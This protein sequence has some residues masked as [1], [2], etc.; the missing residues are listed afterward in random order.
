MAAC[1]VCKK[2][3]NCDHKEMHSVYKCRKEHVFYCCKV[4]CTRAF[5]KRCEKAI[6]QCEKMKKEL[7]TDGHTHG[8]GSALRRLPP[9]EREKFKQIAEAESQSLPICPE[10]AKCKD[11]SV[12]YCC[13]VMLKIGGF[14]NLEKVEETPPALPKLSTGSSRKS[15]AEMELVSDDMLQ[16]IER[17]KDDEDLIVNQK[18]P[19]SA[20]GKKGKLKHKLFLG[21]QPST[22]SFAEDD[23]DSLDAPNSTT[24]TTTASSSEATIFV[25]NR[26]QL[27][28]PAR[29]KGLT[30][31]ERSGK[32]QRFQD[33]F[34][35]CSELRA[36]QILEDNGWDLQKAADNASQAGASSKSK[37][38][39]Q[40]KEQH[41]PRQGPEQVQ[42]QRQTPSRAWREE[43]HAAPPEEVQDSSSSRPPPPAI[44]PDGW[45]AVWDEDHQSYYFWE[46]STNHTQWELPSLQ[47]EAE[48]KISP[49]EELK[50]S[51]DADAKSFKITQMC[52]IIGIDTS[53]AREVLEEHG[54]DLEQSVRTY[55]EKQKR[56]EAARRK[57][58]L[59]PLDKRK[60]EESARPAAQGARQQ[61]AA[62]AEAT[63]TVEA[64]HVDQ[65]SI[66]KQFVCT[67]HWTPRAE[68]AGCLQIFQGERVEVTYSEGAQGWACVRFLEEPSKQ[69]CVPQA[70]LQEA[71]QPGRPRDVGDCC[72]VTEAFRAPE[73]IGG[74]LSV[75]AA[76]QVIVLHPVAGAASSWAFC[77]KAGSQEYG[78]LPECLLD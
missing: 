34:P 53:V 27:K 2:P 54:W 57:A 56:E 43:E 42:E 60:H 12:P 65:A 47:G 38:Q 37:G 58:E 25:P 16:V 66:T 73:Q 31:E 72:R 71:R 64:R 52:N 36:Q 63:Q 70:V 21:C 28:S 10:E 50:G 30:D 49:R 19:K 26:W 45:E 32:V 35:D 11:R 15:P 76:D 55:C 5:E 77:K 17:D 22:E 44:I 61:K 23:D 29:G 3:V 8:T 18:S 6:A 48:T 41:K 68:V 9:P 78:W 14:G 74:Y 13:H 20:K 33:V 46:K 62:A 75:A 40:H 69:G 24:T 67:R 39:R 7:G 51:P 4:E 1:A 59:E